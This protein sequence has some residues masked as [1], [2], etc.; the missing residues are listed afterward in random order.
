MQWRHL[1]ENV[2]VLLGLSIGGHFGLEADLLLSALE[3]A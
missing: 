3:I 2:S 1:N